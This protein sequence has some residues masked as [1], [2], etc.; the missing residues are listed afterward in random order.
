MERA[1][2]EKSSAVDKVKDAEMTKEI[3]EMGTAKQTTITAYMN[4]VK[5]ISNDIRRKIDGK[6]ADL[7]I[8]Y[9]RYVAAIFNGDKTGIQNNLRKLD[10]LATEIQELIGGKNE[11]TNTT[12]S[13]R[14]ITK[15]RSNDRI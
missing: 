9:Y 1:R 13:G 7:F 6:H 10:Q 14:C 12:N 11:D 4:V 5:G 15:T 2:A 8:A 3:E